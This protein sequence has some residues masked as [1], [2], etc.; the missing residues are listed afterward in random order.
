[1]L[2]HLVWDG[3]ATC[4]VTDPKVLL[5]QEA[6]GLL[7]IRHTQLLIHHCESEGVK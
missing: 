3:P 1:M 6:H 2:T 5:M 7:L 4:S